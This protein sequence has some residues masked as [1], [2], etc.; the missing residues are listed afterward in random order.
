MKAVVYARYSTEEQKKESA[1]AQIEACQKLADDHPT[2][3][4]ALLV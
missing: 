4:L 2:W 3:R 1:E